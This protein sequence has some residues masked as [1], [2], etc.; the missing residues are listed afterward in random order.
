MAKKRLWQI[1]LNKYKQSQNAECE[2]VN[3]EMM[4]ANEAKKIEQYFFK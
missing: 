4:F 3:S 2:L 1:T